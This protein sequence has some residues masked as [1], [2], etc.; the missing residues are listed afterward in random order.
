MGAMLDTVRSVETPEGVEIGLRVAG[1]VPRFLAWWIDALVRTGIYTVLSIPLGLLGQSGLGILLVTLFLL[2][3]FYPV[4]FEVLRDGAT[5]GKRGMGLMVLHRDGTPV[6]WSASLLRNLVRF[7]DFLPV[8]YG[9]GLASMLADREFRR[10]GDLAAGTVVVHRDQEAVGA[11][12]P[13]APPVP[14]AAPLSRDEQ[15]AVIDFAE[16]LPTW[17]EQR[18][19]ELARLARP[20]QAGGA[21]S[22]GRGDEVGRLLGIA[23]WLLGRR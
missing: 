8:A 19:R 5:P 22:A 17:S 3:W 13:E 16:R 1:P 9:F 23:N 7:V 15:R 10:L 18:A 11:R 2:E 6:S 20:L 12:V 4:L 14:P 21:G